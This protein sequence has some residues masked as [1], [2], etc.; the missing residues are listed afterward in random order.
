MLLFLP[1]FK[2]IGHL[3]IILSGVMVTPAAVDYVHGNPEWETFLLS[4]A[5]T[6]F[7]GGLGVTFSGGNLKSITRQQAFVLTSMSWVAVSAFGALPFLLGPHGMDATDAI[8]ETVSGLTT[9]GSTVMVDLDS[10]PL[11]ILLWRSL[12]QGIGGIGI[13]VMGISM[14]SFLRVGGMQIFLTESSDSSEKLVPRTQDLAF[15]ITKLYSVLTVACAAG[16][17]AVGM[18]GFDAV[19]HALATVSTG[20]YSTSD[21]SFGKF[22]WPSVQW[23][24]VL[25]MILGSLPF[26][27]YLRSFNNKRLQFFSD[28]QV[29]LMICGLAIVWAIMALW[30]M[31]Q[32]NTPIFEALTAAAFNSTSVVTTTGFASVDY[33]VWGPPA[34]VGFYLL[35]FVGGCSGSTAGGLKMYRLVIMGKVWRQIG[36]RMVHPHALSPVLYMGTP[37]SPA[38]IGSVLSFCLVYVGTILAIALVLAGLGLDFA[39]A[40]SGAA[41][42]V[43]NVGPGVSPLIGPVGN[44]ASLPDAGKWALTAGMLLGRLELMTVYVIFSA[45]FWRH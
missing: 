18:S 3:L 41:T 23:I 25:F 1:A 43:A 7:A 4:A 36:T 13:I 21:Q 20:G 8:F 34:V 33:L 29:R 28:P 10:K 39:S 16:Y 15:T 9:T 6:L 5:V 19:N 17:W 44:F 24:A 27:I 30:Q 14:L 31:V 40:L 26:S 45:G 37:V 35:T 32:F 38:V 42:A 11:G 22:P 12:L 2:T